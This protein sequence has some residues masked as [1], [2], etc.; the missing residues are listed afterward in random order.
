MLCF[1]LA[2]FLWYNEVWMGRTPLSVWKF[3]HEE[4]WW[5][6]DQLKKFSWRKGVKT[7]YLR[8]KNPHHL[9]ENER[10]RII[11]KRLS[12]CIV[13]V[14]LINENARKLKTNEIHFDFLCSFYFQLFHNCWT[15][16]DFELSFFLRKMKKESW[17]YY[18][19]AHKMQLE[20]KVGRTENFQK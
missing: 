4:L 15:L 1:F 10:C 17:K 2:L 3:N 13:F 11:C 18:Y 16:K 8:K 7:I 19:Y 9:Q 5:R 20:A 6:S 14:V 12:I